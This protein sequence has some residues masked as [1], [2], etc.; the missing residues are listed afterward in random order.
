MIE[1]NS[2]ESLKLALLT[3]LSRIGK[4]CLYTASLLSTEEERYRKKTNKLLEF[5]CLFEAE[6]EDI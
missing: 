5:L 6:D 4:H 1:S 2:P 3:Y